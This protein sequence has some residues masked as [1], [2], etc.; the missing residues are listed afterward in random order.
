M[1]CLQMSWVSK[2]RTQGKLEKLEL[3]L[4]SE[5]E[6]E[7]VSG[8]GDLRPSKGLRGHTRRSEDI[9][10]CGNFLM[11]SQTGSLLIPSPLSSIQCMPILSCMP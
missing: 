9:S 7:A 4:D 10:F 8:R 6:L 5:L 1:S 3:E 11:G 2:Q